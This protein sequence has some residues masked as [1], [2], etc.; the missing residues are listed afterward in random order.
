MYVCMYVCMYTPVY[1]SDAQLAIM[2]VKEEELLKRRLRA[3]EEGGKTAWD[4]REIRLAQ[5]AAANRNNTEKAAIEKARLTYEKEQ[6]RGQ[7]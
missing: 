3:E 4:Q 7:G 2:K 5:L 1:L 6:V